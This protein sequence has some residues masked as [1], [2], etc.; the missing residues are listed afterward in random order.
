[1]Q[2]K[3]L[4]IYRVLR[5]VKVY[6]RFISISASITPE[7][8]KNSIIIIELCAFLSGFSLAVWS[9]APQ[10]LSSTHSNPLESSARRV[11]LRC[12][13][14][15]ATPFTI[16]ISTCTGAFFAIIDGLA[17]VIQLVHFQARMA[18]FY[19]FKRFAQTIS[20]IF[21]V[22]F[23]YSFGSHQFKCT[24]SYGELNNIRE[25]QQREISFEY[26]NSLALKE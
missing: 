7:S 20:Y 10:V 22:K 11:S 1:M 5:N 24:S 2:R 14:A 3:L 8:V 16:V 18:R 4:R 26:S 6:F 9:S 23:Q 25:K 15:P 19:S 12:I 21:A 13:T 17:F